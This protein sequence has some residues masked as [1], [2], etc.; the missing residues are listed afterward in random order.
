MNSTTATDVTG[1]K[2]DVKD[3]IISIV[4]FLVAGLCEIGGGY[5]VWKGIRDKPKNPIYIVCGSLILIAYGF[6]PTLQ[7]VD[8][9]G[10]TFA[11]YGGFFIALSYIWS[12]IFDN[13]QLDK[14]DYIGASIS[15]IGVIIAW[16]WPR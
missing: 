2:W 7:P 16:F 15:L 9:F 13:M 14:G 8:S 4:L 11:V 3:V 1:T 10:R 5:L 6:I 12:Y